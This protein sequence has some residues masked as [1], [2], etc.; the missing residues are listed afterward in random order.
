MGNQDTNAGA[1]ISLVA[2]ASAIDGGQ[3][4]VQAFCE[5]YALTPEAS[6]SLELVVE[7][8]V[9]NCLDHGGATGSDGIRLSLTLDQDHVIIFMSDSGQAFDPK[10]DLPQDTRF[11]APDD[12]P[13]G[14]LGWLLINH[15]CELLS[16]ERW[17]DRNELVLRF[18][19]GASQLTRLDAA[20]QR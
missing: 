9:A 12:R 1:Q 10:T 5:Q 16:T 6:A 4:V 15:Y 18:S 8:L 14:G 17:L 11:A 20:R 19:T 2:D 13:I 7:E 3:A